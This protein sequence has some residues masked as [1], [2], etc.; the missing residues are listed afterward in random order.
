MRLPP[1]EWRI[2]RRPVRSVL[3][4]CSGRRRARG[5]PH[6]LPAHPEDG[7]ARRTAPPAVTLSATVTPLTTITHH[8]R[9][10]ALKHAL[11]PRRGTSP[12]RST[13][14]GGGSS[15]AGRRG[16]CSP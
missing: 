7:Q 5:G 16:A 11:T 14:G 10:T 6:H 1:A 15:R 4:E 12:W 2:P 3:A 8:G 13:Y 9:A